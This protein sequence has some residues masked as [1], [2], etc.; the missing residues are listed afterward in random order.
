MEG[1][2]MGSHS[3]HRV[4]LTPEKYI[5]LPYGHDPQQFGDLYLP[6]TPGLHPV[7]ILIHGGFWRAPYNLSLMSGLA[8]DLVKH[9]LA[10]WNIE[11]RR[12][13]DPGGGWPGTLQD[14]GQA[15]DYLTTIAHIYG[16]DLH[17][18][19]AV[20]HS[21]G[22]HLALWLAGRPRLTAKRASSANSSSPLR[23]TAVVSQAGAIDLHTVWRLNLGSGAA[24]E[25][26]GGGPDEVP[27]RYAIAD[28]AALLPLQIPQV[29]I[30]GTQDDR[31]PLKVSQVYQQKALVTGD[32]VHLIELPGADHFVLIEAASA[33]WTTT[34]G[35]IR[36]LLHLV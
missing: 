29:L 2:P 8:E 21:A 9:N 31:V 34:V 17:K 10:T 12:I 15:A 18:I 5:R 20:G 7:V 14:V 33:A 11:Y 1:T 6:N 28:P 30:H 32:T 23:L 36:R 16:L 13:G 25:L 26:L 27:G 4:P 24:A 19:L 35:E 3:S 22:G